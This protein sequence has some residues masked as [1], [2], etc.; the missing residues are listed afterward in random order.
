MVSEESRNT[1]RKNGRSRM[2]RR[3]DE[4]ATEMDDSQLSRWGRLWE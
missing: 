2:R 1:R 4:D 3:L